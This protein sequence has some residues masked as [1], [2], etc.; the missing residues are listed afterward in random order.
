MI[1]WLNGPFGVGKTSVAASLRASMPDSIVF[2]PEVIGTLLHVLVP[3]FRSRDY[4]DMALWRW[5]AREGPRLWQRTGR[6]VI[7]PMTVMDEGHFAEVVESLRLRADV[8]HFTL[9]ASRDEIMRRLGS[10][11]DAAWARERLD[12]AIRALSAPR[13][14]EHID[15]SDATASQVAALIRAKIGRSKSSPGISSERPGS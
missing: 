10:R 12:R 8:R 3:T 14:D 11:A 15:T 6:V 13:F 4:Q 9:M 1:I 5:L 2:D 7:V